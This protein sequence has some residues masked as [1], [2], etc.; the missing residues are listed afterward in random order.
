MEQDLFWIEDEFDILF[1]NKQSFSKG[2]INVAN[3]MLDK[4][5]ENFSN[6]NNEK[7]VQLLAQT[8]ENIRKKY[9]EF[10]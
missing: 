10:F 7:M 1:Q 8:L 6:F 5:T 3:Q 2:D 4:L 9:P